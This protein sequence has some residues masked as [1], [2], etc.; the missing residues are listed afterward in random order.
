MVCVAFS[1]ILTDVWQ[2]GAA[3]AKRVSEL[4]P[5]KTDCPMCSKNQ[6]RELEKHAATKFDHR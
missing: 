4:C 1:R 6:A 3:K 2:N 5:M